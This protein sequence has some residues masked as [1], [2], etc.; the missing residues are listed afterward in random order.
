MNKFLPLF[1]AVIF[2]LAFTFPVNTEKQEK[3][4]LSNDVNDPA[5][6]KALVRKKACTL[7]HDPVKKIVGP[8]FSDIAGKYKGNSAKILEFLEG[9]SNP[10]VQPEEFQYMKPVLEQLKKM[11]D[12]ERKA[13][14]KYISYFTI[15]N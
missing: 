10:I 8:S 2:S 3:I 15:S 4:I 9:K 14:A 11:S 13:I 5:S 7:C 1:I 12:D 6:G